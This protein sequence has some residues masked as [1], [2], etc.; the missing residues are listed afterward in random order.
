MIEKIS[1]LAYFL[2]HMSNKVL[3]K[4]TPEKKH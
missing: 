2:I 4:V 1:E 3:V